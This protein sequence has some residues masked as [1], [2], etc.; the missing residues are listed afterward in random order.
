MMILAR[1]VILTDI[2]VVRTLTGAMSQ[3][4]GT[5]FLEQI[6]GALCK[7]SEDVLG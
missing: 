2:L 4:K 6:L 7:G 3:P 5:Q 1:W